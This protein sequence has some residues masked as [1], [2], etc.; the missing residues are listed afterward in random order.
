M[1]EYNCEASILKRPWPARGYCAAKEKSQNSSDKDVSSAERRWLPEHSSLLFYCQT[2]WLPR[3]IVLTRV[4]KL[5]SKIY[6]YFNEEKT[7]ITHM[8][9]DCEL[10]MQLTL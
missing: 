5:K 1:L 8:I 2:M 7:H 4:F 10:N 3:R 6:Q 9:V